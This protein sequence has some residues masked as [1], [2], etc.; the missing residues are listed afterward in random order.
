MIIRI[1]PKQDE[2]MMYIDSRLDIKDVESR[3]A[4][5][6]SRDFEDDE[7]FLFLLTKRFK[8]NFGNL[9]YT[10]EIKND[11]LVTRVTSISLKKGSWKKLRFI[12]TVSEHSL[13][14][15]VWLQRKKYWNDAV[16]LI[17]LQQLDKE[18]GNGQG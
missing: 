18:F 2:I 3:Q 16:N 8:N 6:Y 13:R 15:R 4:L 9:F 5:I 7:L 1:Y 10:T 17:Y 14:H 12:M 11:I